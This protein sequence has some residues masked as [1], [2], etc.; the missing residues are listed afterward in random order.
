MLAAQ[1]ATC[2]LGCIK[3]RVTSR[4]REVIVPLYS[5]LLRPHSAYCIQVWSPQHKKGVDLLEWVQR[6][7]TKMIK[8]LE[9]LSYVERPQPFFL[10]RRLQGDL[11]ATFQYL[12]GIYKRDRD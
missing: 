6:R 11:I 1:K 5:A 8:G 4:S 12:K 3:S 9:H 10:Q 7:A 2:I